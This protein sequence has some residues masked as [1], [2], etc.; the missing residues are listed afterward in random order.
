MKLLSCIR[1][2]QAIAQSGL[3]YGKGPY[4]LERYAQ[5]QNLAVSML[6]EVTKTQEADLRGLISQDSG[7]ATPKI[8]VRAAVFQENRILMVREREEGLWSLP[9]GWADVNESPSEAITREVFEE[10]GYEVK[11]M[12]LAAVW[13]RN[14]HPHPP[15][16]HHLY[17]AFFICQ[18]EN[19]TPRT[20][21]EIDEIGFFELNRLPP[22]S[23][24]RV[25]LQQI[26]RMFDHMRDMQLPT[27][28]D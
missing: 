16:F 9:G 23:I 25:T 13:D 4:D 15:I 24:Y 10:S 28:F 22:L 2:L 1:E 12:K 11:A 21:H 17:K 19:G 27:D 18:L 7:Y 20:S 14:R 3:F 5:L 26:E 8:D 6:S